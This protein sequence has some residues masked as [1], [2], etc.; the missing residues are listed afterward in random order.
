MTALA[1]GQTESDTTAVQLVQAKSPRTAMIR[2]ALIPGWGQWYNGQKIK[3]AIVLAADLGLIGAGIY[4]NQLAVKS[5]TDYEY[6]HYSYW[7]SQFY[8][9]LIAFRLISMLD[10][11]VD[12]HLFDFDTGPDLSADSPIA[13]RQVRLTMRLPLN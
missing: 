9:W 10:A 3:A 2:S 8:W 5:T 1:R 11:F 12:A 6:E 4:Y 7:R 13:S